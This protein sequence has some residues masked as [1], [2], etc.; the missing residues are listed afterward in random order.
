MVEESTSRSVSSWKR[1]G[2]DVASAFGNVEISTIITQGHKHSVK[3]PCSQDQSPIA[4]HKADVIVHQ[5]CRPRA[6]IAVVKLPTG[7]LSRVPNAGGDP[8][9]EQTA[10]I[11]GRENGRSCHRFNNISINRRI[12][13]LTGAG[14]QLR[15]AA[16]ASSDGSVSLRVTSGPC[17]E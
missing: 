8:R 12:P 11:W 14:R 7:G 10:I 2:L 1:V 3:A 13:P 6:E 16:H 17:A 4:T 15:A 5:E 9:S